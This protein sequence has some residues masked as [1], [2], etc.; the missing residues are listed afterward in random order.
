MN[1]RVFLPL[2]LL[3]LA[4][5]C[6]ETDPH[7]SA[8]MPPALAAGGGSIGLGGASPSDVPDGSPDEVPLE[9][10]ECGAITCE[11]GT[12]STESDSSVCACPDGFGPGTAG[13]PDINECE[14]DGVCPGGTCINVP[15]AFVCECP[16][17][18][19]WDGEIC[20]DVDECA[21]N[22]CAEGATCTN[23]EG[24][25]SCTCPVHQV[26]NG[27]FCKTTPS[28]TDDACGP[29]VC[30]ETPDGHAC[31]CPNGTGG[32]DCG[33]SC[34]T[35]NLDP[36]L[37]AV[38]RA[39]VGLPIEAGPLKPVHV[40]GLTGLNASMSSVVTLDGLECWPELESLDLRAS[41]LG[42][43][44][45]HPFPLQAVASLNR[46][47]NLNLSCTSVTT[48]AGLEG[49]PVLQELRLNQEAPGCSASLTDSSHLRD[50]PSLQTVDLVGNGLGS[51]PALASLSSLRRLFLGDN[52]LTTLAPLD[53]LMLLE[54]VSVPQNSLSSL[55]GLTEARMLRTLD[56]GDNEI[57]SL[58]EVSDLE[59]LTELRIT[60]NDL[61]LV[62][63]V[64]Q[65]SA[66]TFLDASLNRLQT[67]APLAGHPSL[68]EVNVLGNQVSTLTPLVKSGYV[69]V[70]NV[71]EN[72]LL[73][74]EESDNFRVLIAQG[75]RIFGDCR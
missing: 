16:S 71:T 42:S 27:M 64:N 4:L 58:A 19:A 21:F 10:E 24:S 66:L 7:P 51:L 31:Q 53:G 9:G 41:N 3:V 23:F 2:S 69:G 48:L 35:L 11:V 18:L 46:L 25:F 74:D 67:L 36:A 5:G 68:R 75:A 37:D 57:T 65:M 17:G 52:A 45:N 56:A 33:H 54:H 26:G 44:P 34:D 22:P 29:G 59:F 6:S 13:C 20:D 39:L 72:P 30:I 60:N 40:A 55:E 38:V 47:R 1:A 12:C 14:D 70:L 61:E 63:N 28:C 15:G 8:P 50:M 73:C 32:E 43:D 49:H 62:E